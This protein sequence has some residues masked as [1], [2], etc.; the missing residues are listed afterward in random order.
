MDDELAPRLPFVVVGIGASAGRLEAITELVEALRPDTG[1]A[2][3]LIQHLPPNRESMMVEILSRH[4]KMRVLQVED[5]LNVEPDHLYVIR[6]GHTVTIKDAKL[7][8]GQPVEKPGHSR[9]VDDFFK[10]LA[11]EQRERAV[12]II[13]SGMGSNGTAGAQAIKAVGGMRIAQQP[14]TAKFPP[15]PRH[16]ID[17]GHADYILRP[18]DMP[19]ML[20]AYAEHPYARGERE[21]PADKPLLSEQQNLRDIVNVLRAR[22]DQDF[23]G[24]KKPTLLRRIQRRMGLNRMT[25]MGDYAKFLRQ[26][27]NEVNALADDLLIHVTGFFRDKDAWETLRTLAIVPMIAAREPHASVR[28]WVTACSSGEEAYSLAML[29]VEEAERLEKPLDIKVFTTDMAE[30]TLANARGGV[31]PGGI[32]SEISPERLKRFFSQ[33]DA[34]YRV[35]PELRERVIFAPQNLLQDPPFSRLDIV[36]C[37]NLLIYLEPDVQT[38]VLSLLHFGLREGGILFLGSSESAGGKID[39]MFEPIDKKARLFRRIGLTRYGMSDF[40]LPHSLK[41]LSSPIE[42]PMSEPK[43]LGI[44][45]SIAVMS[46]RAL[47]EK[48]TPAAVTIDRDNRIVYFHGDTEPFVASPRGEPTR[49]LMQLLRESVRGAVRMAVHRARSQNATVSVLDGWIEETPGQRFRVSITAS[50]L[51]AKISPDFLVVSFQTLAGPPPETSLND[52][53]NSKQEVSDELARV[54]DE[55]QSTVEELQTSGEE[56]QSLNEELST[57]NSQLQAKIEEQQSTSNDLASLLTSTDIAVLFLD[58]RFYIRRFTPQLRELLDILPSDVGRPLSD[59][60]K[61]FTDPELVRESEDVLNNLAQVER[62]IAGNNGRWFLRRISPYRTADNRIDGVVVTFL[63]ITRRRQTEDVLRA[64]EEQFRKAIEE[65]P[66]PVIFQAEDGRVLQISHTWCELTGLEL[67][68]MPTFDSWLRH[69]TEP[70]AAAIR[71]SFD[72]LFTS[73]ARSI[74]IEF[75]MCGQSNIP[76]RW[77]FSASSPGTLRDGRRFIVGMAVDITDLRREQTSL[78]ES[79]ERLRLLVEGARDFAMIMTDADGRITAWNE[80]AERLLGWTVKQAIARSVTILFTTEDQAAGEPQRKIDEAIETGRTVDARWYVRKDGSR[81]WGCGV[82]TAMTHEDGSLRGLV[83]VLRDD[84]AR[85]EAEDK[86]QTSKDAAE[87]ANR[88]KDAFL[89]TLS[90]ELRTPLSAILIWTRLL[91]ANTELPPDAL[92]GIDAIEFSAHAQKQ[93]IDDLLDTARISSGKLAMDMRP[94]PLTPL[95]QS[96]IEAVRPT[97]GAKAI[98]IDTDFGPDVG[99]VQADPDRLQQVIWN[100]L[101]NAMKFTPESGRIT[102]TVARQGRRVEIRVTDTGAGIDPEFLPRIFKPFTQADP[103]STRTHGGLGLGLAIC[104][105]LV[106]QHGGTITVTSD[107]PGHGSTFTVVLPLPNVPA[108]KPGSPPP[109]RAVDRPRSISHAQQSL[110]G[111]KLLLVEDDPATTNALSVLLRHAGAKV[112]A[113]GSV[114]EALAALKKSTPDLLLSDIGMPGADG[115][116]LIRQVRKDEA[117]NNQPPIHAV[118]LTAF[119]SEADRATALGA[120]F[121][122]HIGKPADPERLISALGEMLAV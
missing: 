19:D 11:A 33:E 54:R 41:K 15:M 14:E 29:L 5:G 38:R 99:I 58:T 2:F 50:P 68:E 30:R 77:S 3:V 71:Q 90:H 64:S 63:D 45:P 82:M 21:A 81:F 8:L 35:L 23:S 94:T 51:D 78:A 42:R 36:S 70:G 32:E 40:P 105:Q 28:C 49:D 86:L 44:R 91:S 119:A 107:G 12:A 61:K 96:A 47:L 95:V 69:V 108:P 93:M 13:L 117:S 37:R 34:V 62:E 103:S 100:L 6:P 1:M 52:A 7:R 98:H 109:A 75:S 111:K 73:H 116:D 60:A 113:A 72:E 43:T 112:V 65:A 53:D 57:V 26:T 79:E 31:Y 92:E 80:G 115:Y 20:L 122:Q 55:L 83:K 66:I 118:A 16:L 46:G 101:N 56:M 76:R 4:T 17:S 114:A 121:N 88:M 87:L 97:A 22:S 110:A 67:L 48:H 120:G 102:V 104:K 9:P 89:A 27:P 106:E 39:D 18:A 10:S 74:S 84:T 85:K 24:Y 25:R 59:L